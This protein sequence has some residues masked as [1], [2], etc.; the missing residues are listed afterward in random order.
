MSGETKSSQGFAREITEVSILCK[1]MKAIFSAMS[2]YAGPMGRPRDVDG[3]AGES[4]PGR[5]IRRWF[6]GASEKVA[7][8][9]I[10]FVAAR[11][12][13]RET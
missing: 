13:R 9:G 6:S 4:S 8:Y 12:R 1:S 7:M 3:V 2:Q 11:E 10:V 5:I